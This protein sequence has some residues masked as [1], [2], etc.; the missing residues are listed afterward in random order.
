[1]PFDVLGRTR[2]TLLRAPGSPLGRPTRVIGKTERD[3]DGGLLF[4][5]LNEEFLVHASQHLAWITSLPFVHT[6]RRYYRWNG[7]VSWGDPRGRKLPKEN[8]IKLAHLEEVKVVTRS[9]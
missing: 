5:L 3:G 4:F 8:P 6:A 9:P 7:L 1:M 2:A